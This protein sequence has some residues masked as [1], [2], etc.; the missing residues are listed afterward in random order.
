MAI[1]GI[2]KPKYHAREK[3]RQNAMR[4]ELNFKNQISRTKLQEPNKI[5]S[6]KSEIRKNTVEKLQ[7]QIT[8]NK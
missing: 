8:K 1:Y 4:E 5:R 3:N 2:Y 6:L 7:D